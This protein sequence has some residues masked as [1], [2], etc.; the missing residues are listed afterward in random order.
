MKNLY[1]AE[2]PSVA[3]EFAKALGMSGGKKDG[4]IEDDDNIV[5]WCVGHLITM[6]YPE[7][8]DENLK[9]W[10]LDPLPFL[11]KPE[12]YK[13]E[14][15]NDVKKQ[16]KTVAELL[17]RKDVGK[18]YYSGDSAREGEYIQRLVRQEAGRNPSA[19][20]RR[21]WIDSQTEEEILRGIR[22]AK[23]LSEYDGLSD[24][25]YA[26]AI[27]DY[28][29][30]I[31]FSRVLSIK[32]ANAVFNSVGMKRGPIAVGRVMSCVLGMVV[33]RERA[34]RNDVKTFY[35]TVSG[36]VEGL[37][38][39]WESKENSS[40]YTPDDLYKNTGFLKKENAD[41]FISSIDQKLEFKGLD[42]KK[43]KKGA[44]LL[45]NLAELQGECTRLFHISPDK[46]L[47]VAQKLYEAKLTTYPRTDARVL[48][49]AVDKVISKNISGLQNVSEV[50]SFATNIMNNKL[51]SNIAHTKYTNDA[52]VSDHYA[53]IPTGETGAL[54]SLSGLEKDVYLLIARRFLSIFYP[55]AEYL[56]AAGKFQSSGENFTIKLSKCVI[57]G[58]L[59]VADKVP[60]DAEADSQ[61]KIL[62]SLSVGTAYDAKYGVKEASTAPP[63]RY[64]T[65]SMVLAMENAG[66]LIEEEELREQ[67]KGAGIG[68]SATRA[69]V[70]KKLA[71]N[72]YIS[73]NNKQV[74]TP[75][76]L[77][78]V[79]YEV[80]KLA[81]PSTLSPKMTASWEQ[82]LSM[83][84]K[85]E[86][87][88]QEYLTKLYGYITQIVNDVKSKDFKEDLKKEIIKLHAAYP[89]MKGKSMDSKTEFDSYKCPHCG[90]EVL[91]GKYGPYCKDKCGMSFMY[92]GKAY[93]E[94]ELKALLANK[95]ITKSGTSKKT[96]N[97]YKMKLTPT[98]IEEYSYNAKDGTK[99][100][101][102]QFTFETEFVDDK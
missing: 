83:I 57:P 102:F 85:G 77:G 84:E 51:Y 4:Y 15:I 49:T 89:Q 86:T 53:I 87:S 21:V 60:E 69:E 98:G 71:K 61:I 14:V 80:L 39:S 58:W 90:G 8:Y 97:P 65:G 82:G 36:L 22:E 68:T 64:T 91:I 29:M 16:Y 43:E 52:A 7:K 18:I 42:K 46:T 2:K 31:N 11:P 10:E 38:T 73:V 23:P 20:E 1:I 62:E 88:Q 41:K 96:G 40:F 92:Y 44:P 95:S 70:I 101:G 99:R 25:A 55:E 37:D 79:I 63:K 78:E 47:S 76:A 3:M 34:I 67:I 54:K 6:S 100:N 45:F 56:K 33:D 75:T 28:S 93:S 66:K 27:E 32:Y 24:S 72:E 26:R 13:Y 35:Y 94:K 48:T 12:N 5:T 50:A 17:N 74:I 9:K 59:E 81:A 30:G 19:E